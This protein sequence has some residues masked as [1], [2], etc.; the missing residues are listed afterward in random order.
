[1]IPEKNMYGR[2]LRS[3]V[4]AFILLVSTVAGAQE[5][6]EQN[7]KNIPG[8]EL[9]HGVVYKVESSMTINSQGAGQPALTV[10]RGSTVT[11]YIPAN[12]KLTVKGHDGEFH[13]PATPGIYVPIGS[14]LIIT[15]EG[16][17]EATGG[18][19][20]M[21]SQGGN[22]GNGWLDWRQNKGYGGKGGSG[23]RGGG[24]AA[25]AIGALGGEGA[26]EK[27]GPIGN[28][29][30]CNGNDFDGD[31]NKGYS[32]NQGARGQDA[33]NVYILGSVTVKTH[34][35]IAT[36]WGA[37]PGSSRGGSGTD[38][39]S[40]WTR[41]YTSGGG[42]PGGGGGM[43]YG[44]RYSIGGGAPG[45]Q[46]GT[47]GGSGGTMKNNT[48]RTYIQGGYGKPGRGGRTPKSTTV[49]NG[50][51][52]SIIFGPTSDYGKTGGWGGDTIA[53]TAGW[54]NN[55]KLCVASTAKVVDDMIPEK[56]KN[57][58]M[59]S[60][61]SVKCYI[62]AYGGTIKKGTTSQSED[63][64]T[65][66][67]GTMPNQ[68]II[69]T[70]GKKSFDGYY[71][72][73]DV[74][75]FDATGNCTG[76]NTR[77]KSFTVYARWYD[78]YVDFGTISL[79]TGYTATE[80]TEV[81]LVRKD[82]PQIVTPKAGSEVSFD[83][84]LRS[85]G[86]YEGDKLVRHYVPAHKVQAPGDTTVCLFEELTRTYLLCKKD[87]KYPM[88]Y[89][90]GNC[91][92]ALMG[93]R[94]A[95]HTI[96]SGTKE[97]GSSYDLKQCY[98]CE[99]P[100][101]VP[102]DNDYIGLTGN[103][104][105]NTEYA[106]KPNTSIFTRMQY[107]SP[108]FKQSQLNASRMY[109]SE[110]YNS[111]IP[112]L[113]GWRYASAR[114]L[115]T[116]DVFNNRKGKITEISYE[117]LS[118]QDKSPFTS[119][120]KIYMMLTDKDY[121][122]QTYISNFTLV[123]D[124]DVTEDPKTNTT[125]KLQTPFKYDGKSNLVVAIFQKNETT[126]SLIYKV[127]STDEGKP[128]KSIYRYSSSIEEYG[129]PEYMYSYNS[130]K[131][132]IPHTMFVLEEDDNTEPIP[133]GTTDESNQFAMGMHYSRGEGFFNTYMN[134]GTKQYGKEGETILFPEID[135][136]IL[137]MNNN[138]VVSETELATKSVIE[139]EW[140]AATSFSTQP[141]YIGAGNNSGKTENGMA[142]RVYDFTIMEDGKP[143]HKYI[144]AIY[145]DKA[146]L[147]DEVLDTTFIF[148][149]DNMGAKAL[150]HKKR[151]VHRYRTTRKDG[152]VERRCQVCDNLPEKT[153]YKDI[154]FHPGATNVDGI[155]QPQTIDISGHLTKN[156]FSR[157]MYAF[158]GWSKTKGSS[159]I[160]YSEQ[161]YIKPTEKDCGKMDLYAVW[162]EC[163]VVRTDTIAIPA[164]NVVESICTEDRSME[165]TGMATRRPI[166]I[167]NFE[168]YRELPAGTVW[169][170]VCLPIPL[171][172]DESVTYYTKARVQGGKLILTRASN[173]APNSPCIYHV[174]NDVK[175]LWLKG[176]QAYFDGK[177]ENSVGDGGLEIV[178]TYEDLQIDCSGTGNDYYVIN[179]N[180][181]YH[182]KSSVDVTPFRAYLKAPMGTTSARELIIVEEGETSAEAITDYELR[183]ADGKYLEDGKV[184]IYTG[185]KKYDINGRRNK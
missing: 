20:G 99:F 124:G 29:L 166:T 67:Y 76:L 87:E 7:L 70:N 175:Y 14:T 169:G 58:S 50:I 154:T 82:K 69:P 133:F 114:Y 178:G 8:L 25:P 3:L 130:A 85:V 152:V 127:F 55:G 60:I 92:H 143:V 9:Q 79:N 45:G 71:T 139:E 84:D 100:K 158:K 185:D 116:S 170:T 78:A 132:Q 160:D 144:P 91:N 140:P 172:S 103:N 104:Y 86:I 31:G 30:F 151:C 101:Q 17:L 128:S 162:D 90:D 109:K 176:T 53:N 138:L 153:Y 93:G 44:A 59:P 184:V 102:T 43:G 137:A 145:N 5:I 129:D 38:A 107:S 115:Y 18:N 68:V 13:F 168:Y 121:L 181:F 97:D 134:V 37:M 180:I 46:S 56:E 177:A 2:M 4:V 36:G 96:S 98:L 81:I 16:E 80:K 119:N 42:G 110:A 47:T 54:G 77:T 125:I 108:S 32:S 167:K 64:T 6:K 61:I 26:L 62:D 173:V 51:D 164:N 39:G 21:G 149:S 57:W 33:G 40:G 141:L 11:I 126:Y 63:T 148:K 72:S 150:I 65:L 1:M 10:T 135:Y 95:F 23:G 111:S 156:G 131:N 89:T 146:G 75:V 136:D 122:Y 52:H 117:P 163:Y 179:D 88:D 74:Q 123:Y 113:S 83:G 147:Y 171:K 22:G 28:T 165:R 34:R 66:Y 120:K 159:N 15:G 12:V 24:G 105:I 161:A 48:G 182:V 174:K 157:P 41:N 118:G 112:L 19:A 73:D 27:E 155:M 49:V 183:I 35:G 142:G 106:M 94:S